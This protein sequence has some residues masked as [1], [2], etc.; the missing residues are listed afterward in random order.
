ME[1]QASRVYANALLELAVESNSIEATEEELLDIAALFA[2]DET[3]RQ[4]FFSPIV[5]SAQKEQILTK[6]F[7]GKISEQTLSFLAVVVRKSRINLI[8]DIASSFTKALDKFK[9]R[10]RVTVYSQ[11]KLDAST[12][13]KLKF[14]LNKKTNGEAI[15]RNET[16]PNLVGGFVLEFGD[17]IID[18]SIS[19]QLEN[20]RSLLLQKNLSSEALYEN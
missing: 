15:L 7:S 11:T 19:F 20:F 18:S 3:L 2:K 13:D 5:S 10:T 8:A 16:K 4:F 9:G 14:I 6:S 17:T 1:Q 12:L